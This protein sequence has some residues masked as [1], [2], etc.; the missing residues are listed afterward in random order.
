MSYSHQRIGVFQSAVRTALQGAGDVSQS[1]YD[2]EDR[3]EVSV[4]IAIHSPAAPPNR[5]GIEKRTRPVRTLH[6]QD[7]QLVAG[8]AIC[9]AACTHSWRFI[10]RSILRT[11]LFSCLP[12]IAGCIA[13]LPVAEF[14]P[15]TMGGGT[16]Q[17]NCVGAKYVFYNFDGVQ[18]WVDLRG[19]GEGYPP[20]QLVMGLK[21]ADRRVARIPAPEIR[22]KVLADGKE[23]SRPLPAWERSV[24]L[25]MKPTSNWFKQVIVETGP[26]S[27][28]LIG[29]TP[30]DGDNVMFKSIAKS[31]TV[32]IPM[33]GL[34][35]AGY[36]VQ[37]PSIEIDGKAH[38]F[39]PIEYRQQH[40]LAFMVPLNC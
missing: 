38:T 24:A 10:M 39:A 27:G 28:P 31:F 25:S 5:A 17:T 12:A 35:T 3:G 6:L 26:A 21:L 33:G 4:E 29:G 34:P 22:I 13:V 32:S 20:P 23:A 7:C 14:I 40:R 2:R 16:I 30:D 1:E 18:V 8:P 11:A 9:H 19:S 36:R 37:L 15:A